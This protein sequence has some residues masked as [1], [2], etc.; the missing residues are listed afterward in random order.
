MKHILAL[1]ICSYLLFSCH[2]GKSENANIADPIIKPATEVSIAFPSDTAKLANVV[3]LNATASYLLKSDVKANTNGYITK[4]TIK[5]ADHVN[6]GMLL[7]GLET[8]EARALGNTINKLDPSFHF[9]GNTT[10]VSPATGYVAM[11]NH[12]IGDYVQDGEILATI[13]DANSFGFVVDVPYEYLQVVKSKKIL[14]I[15]LPDGIVLQGSIAKVMPTV[16][17][18][19]QTVKILLKVAPN[20]I[21]ENLIGTISFSKNLDYGL[22]VPKMAVLS[23]EGQTSFWVMK[24]MN[25]STAIKTIIEKGI[26]TDKFIQVKS[27]D[28]TTK[29]RVLISGNFGLADTAAVHIRTNGKR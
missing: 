14:P 19:S 17:A 8:K 29:D 24:L 18:V 27:G 16:D 3:T 26:E 4:I 22:S 28:L 21:P 23:D 15:T 9:N 10:V 20:D 6:K 5:M 25:D 11:L 1:F 7:F 2:S 12:Q 13:T